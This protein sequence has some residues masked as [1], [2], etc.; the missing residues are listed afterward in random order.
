MHTAYLCVEHPPC[1]ITHDAVESDVLPKLI[2]TEQLARQ[3]QD[4][5]VVVLDRHKLYRAVGFLHTRT[6]HWS[7]KSREKQQLDLG[8][9]D[10]RQDEVRVGGRFVPQAQ[11]QAFVF[12]SR[13]GQLLDLGA[14]VVEHVAP[15]GA[16]ISWFS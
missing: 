4:D 6:F 9:R 3:G 14:I 11:R 7:T 2:D 8:C 1:S 13:D 15:D 16:L 12:R 5:L 10:V